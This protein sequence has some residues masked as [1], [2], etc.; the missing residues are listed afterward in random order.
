M[1]FALLEYILGFLR[2]RLQVLLHS[3]LCM[4][5][6]PDCTQSQRAVICTGCKSSY[7]LRILG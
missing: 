5:I 4:L 2:R 1:L 3:G 7:L 6:R